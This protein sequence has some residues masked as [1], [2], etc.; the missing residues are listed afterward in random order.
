M[1]GCVQEKVLKPSQIS[2]EQL[3]TAI[4]EPKTTTIFVHFPLSTAGYAAFLMAHQQGKSWLWWYNRCPPPPNPIPGVAQ[5]NRRFA[6]L[7][8][9]LP[10]LDDGD[11]R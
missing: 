4:A 2:I 1:G 3:A 9:E 5:S 8:G 11:M 6:P 7:E 10:V